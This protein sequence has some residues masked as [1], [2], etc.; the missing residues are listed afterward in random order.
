MASVRRQIAA[1]L[2]AEGPRFGAY[3]VGYDLGATLVACGD[4]DAALLTDPGALYD[5]GTPL[6]KHPDRLAR[7]S[8]LTL[9]TLAEEGLVDSSRL[10]RPLWKEFTDLTARDAYDVWLVARR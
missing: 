8:N 10:P 9:A 2:R 5:L 3:S 1:S 4:A 7:L 6:R